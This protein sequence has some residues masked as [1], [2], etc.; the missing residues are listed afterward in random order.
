M[1]DIRDELPS[2]MDM[3]PEV[4]GP[5]FEWQRQL[6]LSVTFAERKWMEEGDLVRMGIRVFELLELTAVPGVGPCY[7]VRPFSCTVTPA[8]L[9]KLLGGEE[10]AGP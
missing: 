9:N 3:I 8:D 1:S 6:W 5:T 4:E 7:L 10:L 2:L